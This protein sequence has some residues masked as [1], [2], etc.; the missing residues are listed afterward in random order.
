MTQRKI[1]FDVSE[2]TNVRSSQ[3]TFNCMRQS[4]DAW[5]I[6]EILLLFESKTKICRNAPVV[7]I[8]QRNRDSTISSNAQLNESMQF[9]SLIDQSWYEARGKI[10]VKSKGLS[11]ACNSNERRVYLEGVQRIESSWV[12]NVFDLGGSRRYSRAKAS[13]VIIEEYQ[14]AITP[15]RRMYSSPSIMI[16]SHDAR[17]GIVGCN[18]QVHRW[19]QCAKLPWFMAMNNIVLCARV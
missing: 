13:F 7:E 19:I 16:N 9:I 5:I 12:G 1:L 8:S 15:Q 11:F 18:A 2:G 10:R 3:I 6:F 4:F 17:N 14:N